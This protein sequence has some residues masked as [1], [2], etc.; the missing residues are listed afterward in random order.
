MVAGLQSRPTR[1]KDR[2]VGRSEKGV[3]Q[4]VIGHQLCVEDM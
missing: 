4:T 1:V 3:S 2:E